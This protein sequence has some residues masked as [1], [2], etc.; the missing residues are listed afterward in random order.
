MERMKPLNDYVFKKLFGEEDTKDNLISLL[1]AILNKNDRE[2]LVTIEIIENKELT[3]ELIDDKTGILDVR[4]KT[5]DG[6]QL[7]IEVQ[8]TNQNNMDKRTIWYWGRIFN[9][10]IK[11]GEDYKDLCKVITINIVDFEYVKIE[12]KFHTTF[13]LWEDEA[14]E[15]MLTDLIEIDFIDVAK[16]RKLS[17]KNL[18]EDKLQR[19]LT[20]FKEDISEEELKELMEMDEDI[21]KAEEKIE[22]LSSDP[23]TIELYKVRERSLHDRMNMINGAKEKGKAEV[24]K[25][26]LQ[27]GMNILDVIKATGLKEEDIKRIKENMH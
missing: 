5:E 20:F 22:Y 8:L 18:K 9:E 15:Y 13:H 11:I 12:N 27:I 1:N 6:M 23:K 2:K 14:K 17:V 16:F 4:A 24:A 10:G 3:R 19:W 21:K 25:N 7:D 26:L